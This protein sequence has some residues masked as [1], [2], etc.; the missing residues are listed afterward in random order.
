MV[1]PKKSAKSLLFENS[2]SKFVRFKKQTTFT[3]LHWRMRVISANTSGF[4][5]GKPFKNFETL[6]LFVKTSLI[7]WGLQRAKTE[8]KSFAGMF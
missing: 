5:E 6:F 2:S 1:N 3:P 4:A 8:I 7:D